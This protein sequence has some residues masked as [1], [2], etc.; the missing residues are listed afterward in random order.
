MEWRVEPEPAFGWKRGRHFYVCDQKL[1]V[2]EFSG[3][4]RADDPPQRRS[5]A[6]A[7]GEIAGAEIV[8]AVRRFHRQHH[9]VVVLLQ[10]NDSV[11]PAQINSGKFLHAVDQ[12]GFGIVLLK[13]D[14]GRPGARPVA[15]RTGRAASRRE[16]SCRRSRPLPCRPCV[17]RRR[18]GPT[19]PAIAWKNRSRASRRRSCLSSSSTTAVR[20]VPNRSRVRVQSVRR[21]RHSGMVYR[22]RAVSST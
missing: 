15:G 7:G 18:A 19:I 6:V 13:V 14:E 10:R 21:R 17:R 8:S 20:V 5:C 11:S 1:V 22:N 4:F 9:V 12:I 3:E 2:E 16:I